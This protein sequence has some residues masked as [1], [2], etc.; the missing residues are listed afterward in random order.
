MGRILSAPLMVCVLAGHIGLI[1]C[2]CH[3]MVHSSGK[4]ILSR[5]AIL[6]KASFLD[7]FSSG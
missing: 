6:T 3:S 1:C 2:Y 4:N 7:I 5:R